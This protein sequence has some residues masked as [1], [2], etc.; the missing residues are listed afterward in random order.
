MAIDSVHVRAALA[1]IRGE[2]A[3]IC[4]RSGRRPDEIDI[5]AVTKG[6]GPEA[7]SAA[8]AAG[9]AD[10]GE[11]YYQE[12]AAKFA[13]AAW[14]SIPFRKHFIGRIQHNKA[15]RIAAIFDVVQTMQDEKIAIALDAGAADAGKTLDVLIQANVA[16]DERQGVPPEQVGAFAQ[17]LRRLS[18]L[19]LRGIMAIGPNDPA[20][21]EDAFNLAA[22]LY[23]TLQQSD[24][25]IRMLSIGM[26][27][28]MDAAV[29]AGAT[30][31]RLGTALFGSRPAAP[32]LNPANATK[33]EG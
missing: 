22:G 11:N 21:S 25:R 33:G 3:N 27:G 31:L 24:S 15:R 19:R 32:A 7:I 5:I 16:G 6:F 4:E 9:L 14:P 12:A 28:D 2:I 23:T 8:F 10:I 13:Q 30:M 29:R 18:H 26:S 20:R 17:T 1:K